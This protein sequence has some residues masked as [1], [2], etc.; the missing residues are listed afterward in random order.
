M[1]S[2]RGEYDNVADEN[3]AMLRFMKSILEEEKAKGVGLDL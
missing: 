1:Q 3:P 2:D